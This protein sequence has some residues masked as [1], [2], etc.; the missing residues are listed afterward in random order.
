MYIIVMLQA[1]LITLVSLFQGGPYIERFHF[2]HVQGTVHGQI[3]YRNGSK[4]P[5]SHLNRYIPQML[6]Y[7]NYFKE[8]S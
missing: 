5:M 6:S 8:L 4:W 2:I 7:I 3:W 1:V